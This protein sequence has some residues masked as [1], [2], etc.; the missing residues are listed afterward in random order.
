[1]LEDI[2]AAVE[3][4]HY[5]GKIG[6]RSAG[7]VES[8]GSAVR[9]TM[10]VLGINL[11]VLLPFLVLLVIFAP[12]AALLMI[13]VNGYLLG[14]EY[15]ELVAVRHLPSKEANALRSKFSGRVWFAGI[16][17]AAPLSIPLLNLIVPVLGVATITHQFHRLRSGTT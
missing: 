17:M 6:T 4:R 8:I 10:V 11:L 16:C 7:L 12:L 9:F 15:F 3:A 13:C 14:R 5:P 2:A 1:F